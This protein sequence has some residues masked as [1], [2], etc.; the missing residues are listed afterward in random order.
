MS[1]PDDA[2]P[3]PVRLTWRIALRTKWTVKEAT[4]GKK[5]GF[6][7]PRGKEWRSMSGAFNG[8][9]LYLGDVADDD[10][11]CRYYLPSQVKIADFLRCERETVRLYFRAAEAAGVITLM[12]S[13]K[14][15]INGFQLLMPPGGRPRWE[16]ANAVLRGDRRRVDMEYRRVMGADE[17]VSRDLTS[18]QG[19]VA[20]RDITSPEAVGEQVASRDEAKWRHVTEQVESGDTTPRPTRQNT[21]MAGSVNPATGRGWSGEEK[22]DHSAADEAATEL[23]ADGRMHLLM[24]L[25]L[26]SQQQPAPPAA[27]AGEGGAP[28]IPDARAKTDELRALARTRRA[29]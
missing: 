9:L 5:D 7:A 14:G 4:K 21:L 19:H 6:A 26:A 22:Q 27:P 16:D 11:H 18:P 17:V 12:H 29:S 3:T 8:F 20:S 2:K 13:P 28:N 1:A 23:D 15:Q 10:G 24:P 25:R